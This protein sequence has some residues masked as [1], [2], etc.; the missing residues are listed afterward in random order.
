MR[1]EELPN[2]AQPHYQSNLKKGETQ[3]GQAMNSR[4]NKKLILEDVQ[5]IVE[6]NLGL[7]CGRR[8]RLP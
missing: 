4:G 3:T 1:A 6:V 7:N 2:E 8:P 5:E